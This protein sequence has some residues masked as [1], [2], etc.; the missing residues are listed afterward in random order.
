MTRDQMIQYMVQQH[1]CR[2]ITF[3]EFAE[4][5]DLDAEGPA[6]IL[7][8]LDRLLSLPHDSIPLAMASLEIARRQ[9]LG[10]DDWQGRPV[11]DDFFLEARRPTTGSE[12]ERWHDCL[13]I[14]L[15]QMRL[16]LET[17]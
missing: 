12:K 8:I 15:L 14:P 2:V 4:E 13:V 17:K 6:I 10:D 11:K 9:L 5:C 7:P 1:G 3:Q 16:D